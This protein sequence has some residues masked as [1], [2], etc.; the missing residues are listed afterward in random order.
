MI[1]IR[2]IHNPTLFLADMATI[3][4]VPRKF[5]LNCSLPK[6]F[7]D[8]GKNIFFLACPQKQR[9]KVLPVFDSGVEIVVSTCTPRCWIALLCGYR[10]RG[11][12]FLSE[13]A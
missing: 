6:M 10:Y 2:N 7:I 3:P 4:N 1:T 5:E 8:P 13:T 12:D 9:R 11:T